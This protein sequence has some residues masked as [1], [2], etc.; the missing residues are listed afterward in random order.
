VLILSLPGGRGPEL[1][2]WLADHCFTRRDSVAADLS[3]DIACGIDQVH[4]Q[5]HLADCVS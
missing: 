4:K 5:R 3:H 2:W 1:W